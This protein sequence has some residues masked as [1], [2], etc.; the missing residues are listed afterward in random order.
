MWACTRARTRQCVFILIS[1]STSVHYHLPG[2]VNDSLLLV[3]PAGFV[4][5]TLLKKLNTHLQIR[6]NQMPKPFFKKDIYLNIQYKKSL[7]YMFVLFKPSCLSCCLCVGWNCFCA[8]VLHSPGVKCRCALICFTQTFTLQPIFSSDNYMFSCKFCPILQQ[9]LSCRQ[10]PSVA[11]IAGAVTFTAV[12]MSHQNGSE[13]LKASL[14]N[15]DNLF[16]MSPHPCMF[17]LVPN[18]TIALQYKCFHLSPIPISFSTFQVGRTFWFLLIHIP[19]LDAKTLMY[20]QKDPG[21][22]RDTLK[23]WT[24]LEF[25]YLVKKM[26]HIYECIYFFFKGQQFKQFSTSALYDL[27]PWSSVLIAAKTPTV[28]FLMRW[29]AFMVVC[30]GQIKLLQPKN[31]Q[32]TCRK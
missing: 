29:A 4:M 14:C 1:V 23:T 15:Q 8:C 30:W 13:A 21:G 22:S 20:P 10:K 16:H 6:H 32:K 3:H 5:S 24:M 27:R 28:I 11:F 18:Q 26:K 19:A 2:Y 9:H 31:D 12:F 25:C 17:T 7:V